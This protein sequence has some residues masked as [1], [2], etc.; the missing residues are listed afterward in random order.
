MRGADFLCE[1]R[2]AEAGLAED[3]VAGGAEEE[4][5]GGDEEGESHSPDVADEA[6][7]AGDAAA[8]EHADVPC[9]GEQGDHGEN[10]VADCVAFFLRLKS[11]CERGESCR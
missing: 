11:E 8:D 2:G 6:L 3:W 9:G 5:A 4:G 1:D 10:A 7:D